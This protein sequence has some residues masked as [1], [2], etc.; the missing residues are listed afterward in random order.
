M[1]RFWLIL[2]VGVA[3]ALLSIAYRVLSNGDSPSRSAGPGVEPRAD[4]PPAKAPVSPGLPVLFQLRDV[5]EETGITYRHT[6]GSSGKYYIPETVT[7]GLATFDF[8]GDTLIDIYFPNGAPLPGTEVTE[9]PRHALYRNLGGWHFEDVTE[10]AGVACREFGMGAA[11]ADFDQDGFA[12]LY[13]SN[14]GPKVLYRNNGDGTF[15]DV[16]KQAGVADG[17]MLGAGVCFLD[18][19]GDGDL[20]LFV[21]NYLEFSYD[22]HVVLNRYGYP[23][24]VGPT[25]YPPEKLTLYRNEGD[26]TFSDANRD[27]GV[28]RY[29]GKGMGVVAADYDRDGDT[30]I[31]V[32]NDVFQNFCLQ[33]DGTG[34]S[35]TWRCCAASST[36]ATGSP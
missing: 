27:S 8:D 2:A 20:D 29:P 14:F 19:E 5:T 23:E 17:E 35:R 12:D 34:D 18:A 22:K 24:Y 16:S 6:D 13:V 4:G 3:V 33:N 9:P 15:A 36:T 25:A 11:V 21:A 31:F 30:D 32:L 7:A 28:G 26:G 1:R 10:S